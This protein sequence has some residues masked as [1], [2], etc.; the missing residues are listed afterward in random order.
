MASDQK[1]VERVIKKLRI[2]QTSD[3]QSLGTQK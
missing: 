2:A 1:A 3:W